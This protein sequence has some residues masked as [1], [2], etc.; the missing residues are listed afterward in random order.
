MRKLLPAVVC[1]SV[2][3]SG[4]GRKKQPTV[5]LDEPVDVLV[6]SGRGKLYQPGRAFRD[7]EIGPE[8]P[9][10]ADVYRIRTGDA[11]EVGVWGE[12]DMTKRITVGPDGRIS[13]FLATEVLASGRTLKELKSHLRQRLKKHYKDPEVFVSLV[14]S[15]GNFVSVTGIIKKP[16]IYKISNESRLVDIIAQAGGIPLGSTQFGQGITE[17][18]DLSQAFV[19]RGSRFVNVD[20]EKL[21]R[22]K[23]A[24]AREIAMNNILLQ[25]NDRIYVPSAV[26]LD[27][28][29]FIVGAVR[30]PRMIRY[31]KDI[32]FLEALVRAGDVPEQAWERKSFIVRGRMNNPKIIPVN[33]RLVRQGRIADIRLQAGDV[34]FMPKTP[35]A[36]TVEVIRQLDSIFGGMTSAERASKVR[37]F[38]R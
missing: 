3:A 20:F 1:L 24:T 13:Y 18:A 6:E 23:P 8:P 25:P 15:A 35:L 30:A 17:V 16:G 10:I 37:M 5:R 9:R 36:K 38:D 28:K 14:S 2:I 33:S 29:V 12:N 19:L 4:C 7:M 31:S 32:T 34:I 22:R 11:L 26:Q 27:N 21:F